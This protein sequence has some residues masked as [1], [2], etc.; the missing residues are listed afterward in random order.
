MWSHA[1]A[2]IP[3]MH[4][5]V[6]VARGLE[7]SP[8]RTWLKDVARRVLLAEGVDNA[9]MELVITSSEKVRDLNRDYRGLDEPTD[10]LAF[11]ATEQAVGAPPFVGPPGETR[12]LGEVI[13]AYPEAI[14]QAAEHHHPVEQEMA[15]LIIHGILHLLGY[16]HDEPKAES[17]MRGREKEILAA[18]L[19]GRD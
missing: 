18:V 5:D 19:G 4:I 1:H 16:D 2:M 9:E 14:G 11:A 12:H 7:G 10:V 3:Q 8:K 13:I 17:R 6:L 15:L